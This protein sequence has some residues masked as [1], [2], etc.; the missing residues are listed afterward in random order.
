MADFEQ[1]GA[2]ERLRRVAILRDMQAKLKRSPLEAI[3]VVAGASAAEVRSAFME[4][5]KQYHPA[6]FARLDEATV[7]LANEVFLDLRE[8]YESLQAAANGKRARTIPGPGPGIAELEPTKKPE[9]A[10]Q[11]A[12]SA[13]SSQANAPAAGAGRSSQAPRPVDPSRA[14]PQRP[15]VRSADSTNTTA[16][17]AATT[18]AG[19]RPGVRAVTHS[20]AGSS[21]DRLPS[22]APARAV[23]HSDAG[24]SADRPPSGAPER[25]TVGRAPQVASPSASAAHSSSVAGASS[26]GRSTSLH[27]AG[28][29]AG[30]SPASAPAGPLT[31]PSAPSISTST[32]ASIGASIGTSAGTSANASVPRFPSASASASSRP[33]AVPAVPAVPTAGPGKIV[34]TPQAAA[35]S[36]TVPNAAGATTGAPKLR[37]G[38][39]EAPELVRIRG[40]INRQQWTAA[41][42]ALQLML[43]RAPTD[44]GSMAQLAYVRAREAL[45]LGNVSEARR[46]LVRALAIE[47]AME[48]A[49]SA[50]NDLNDL[51]PSNPSSPPSAPRR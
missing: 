44:R 3:G 24:S 7:K 25:P 1:A 29:A 16:A 51:N 4:L 23:T 20:D 27:P 18:R 43:Q 12:A 11:A 28:S 14:E 15:S 33:P 42:D 39:A 50:L 41:R 31:R 13:Q 8:A 36:S 10:G 35:S 5:T 9:P 32:S 37:F 34:A 49:R 47:P 17:A 40:L 19:V 21:A 45:E 26:G 6:K 30:R 2:T 22:G 46:E 38:S 48:Q